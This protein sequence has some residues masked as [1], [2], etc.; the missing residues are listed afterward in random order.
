MTKWASKPINTIRG[1]KVLSSLLLLLIFLFFIS[2]KQTLLL[3]DA[4]TGDELVSFSSGKGFSVAYTHSVERTEV[5]ENYSFEKGGFTLTDTWFHSYGAGLPATTEYD[6]EITPEG[7][8]IYNINK[9]F[10]EVIYRT[11]KRRANHRLLI[12]KK[13]YLFAEFSRPGQAVLFRMEKEP[14]WKLLLGGVH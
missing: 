9:Y 6:F 5:I 1:K 11:G 8:H 3:S 7:F 2:S 13:E 14:R 12:G 4:F 10:E